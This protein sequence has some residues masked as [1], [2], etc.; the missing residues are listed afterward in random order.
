MLSAMNAIETTTAAN[1]SRKSSTPFNCRSAVTMRL[2][3]NPNAPK[4]YPGPMTTRWSRRISAPKRPVAAP[5]GSLGRGMP[6]DTTRRRGGR[7][8]HEIPFAPLSPA[9]SPATAAEASRG[10][11]MAQTNQSVAVPRGPSTVTT[12]AG[13][14]TSMAR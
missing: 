11:R 7:R 5:M 8:R 13:H 1:V 3:T 9:A 2:A 12:K 10:C 14:A 4:P 6:V